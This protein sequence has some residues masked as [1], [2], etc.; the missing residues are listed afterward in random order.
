MLRVISGSK[1]GKKLLVPEGE[2]RAVTDR[3][4]TIVFDWIQFELGGKKILDLYAGSG[5]YGIEALSRGAD[6]C[7]F[8]D[9][10][11]NAI[12]AIEKNLRETDLHRQAKTLKGR[13]P[14]VLEVQEI[15]KMT[16]DIAFIDP[17]FKK[18]G[19]FD[20]EEIMRRIKFAEE[21]IVIL[22]IPANE[23]IDLACF[24]LIKQKKIGKSM[25]F[26]LRKVAK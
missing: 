8:V 18:L 1:K 20:I 23:I 26:L 12:T 15:S 4:K 21:N 13:I 5:A 11:E 10:G 3:I 9:Y 17:P 19:E 7:I 25:L 22:R 24:E 6:S 16:F 14:N 2:T